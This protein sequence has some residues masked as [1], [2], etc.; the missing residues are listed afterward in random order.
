MTLGSALQIA[1]SPDGGLAA[2]QR[3]LEMHQRLCASDPSDSAACRGIF[4][5]YYKIGNLE[6]ARNHEEEA[7]QAYREAT[8]IAEE[9]HRRE[10]GNGMYQRD[11]AFASGGLGITLLD[12]A[13]A[14]GAEEQF[15]RQSDLL[16]SLAEADPGNANPRIWLGEAIRNV[17]NALLAG[18]DISGGRR[19]LVESASSLESIV[20]ADPTSVSARIELAQT[21]RDLGR[22]YSTGAGAGPRDGRAWYEKARTQFLELRREGKLAPSTETL[23]TRVDE[24]IA[25]LDKRSGG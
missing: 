1:N 12:Q 14:P 24:E 23:L 21:Y 9:F 15:R 10:P 19:R 18:G 4:V 2:F 25:R 22:T 8:R 7:A 3:G 6:V 16:R 11:L 5:G 17:G 20:T 13:D